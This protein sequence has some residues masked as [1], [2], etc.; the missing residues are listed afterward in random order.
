MSNRRRSSSRRSRLRSAFVTA[1]SSTARSNIGSGLDRLG[2]LPSVTPGHEHGVELAADGAV[3]GQH[4]HGVGSRAFP[5]GVAGAVLAGVERLEERL[6]ARVGARLVGLGHHVR[7][8]HDGV[9]LATGLGALPG[10]VDEPSRAG[11]VLPQVPERVLHAHAGEQGGARERLARGHDRLGLGGGEPFG[12]VERVRDRAGARA[13]RPQQPPG[14]R[15]REPD[16]VGDE[17]LL[18]QH[19]ASRA[20]RPRATGAR[21]RTVGWPARR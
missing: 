6:D 14:R 21:A 1:R 4:L 13:R 2:K 3:G 12:D 16:D 9:E 18:D 15:G 8:R 17:E 10:A 20:R 19:L 5:R 7:E 11:K